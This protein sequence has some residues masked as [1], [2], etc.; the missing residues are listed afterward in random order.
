MPSISEDEEENEDNNNDIDVSSKERS[1]R[2]DIE[3]DPGDGKGNTS[4]VPLLT[5]LGHDHG[6]VGSSDWLAGRSRLPNGHI[7]SAIRYIVQ[8]YMN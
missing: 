8:L 4:F 1:K 2:D 3:E 5:Q 6:S 7:G